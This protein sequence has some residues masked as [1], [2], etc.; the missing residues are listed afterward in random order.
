M[1]KLTL[2]C[3]LLFVST[4]WIACKKDTVTEDPAPAET[5]ATD[6]TSSANETTAANETTPETTPEAK[7]SIEGG[8]AWNHIVEVFDGEEPADE[9]VTDCL[10]IKQGD[11]PDRISFAFELV[12]TNAHTCS[13]SG[14]ATADG[15]NRWVYIEENEEEGFSCRLEIVASDKTIELKD[16][17]GCRD[18]YCG[19]RGYIDGA[20]FERSTHRPDDFSCAESN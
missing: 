20:S 18:Y 7:T 11:E 6:E 5:S 2:T 16:P 19:A 4:S 3:L 10:S 17:S 12:H 14:V 9:E 15:E 13:M 8:Y 1:N